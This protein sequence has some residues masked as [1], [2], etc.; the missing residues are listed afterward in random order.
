MIR[1]DLWISL[2][3]KSVHIN[4]PQV[5]L[6][7]FQKSCSFENSGMSKSRSSIC[8]KKTTLIQTMAVVVFRTQGT[9]RF[10]L[11]AAQDTSLISG[12]TAGSKPHLP[13]KHQHNFPNCGS[14]FRNNSQAD[15]KH[16]S[17]PGELEWHPTLSQW[18]W[19]GILRLEKSP[20]WDYLGRVDAHSIQDP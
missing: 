2:Q 10:F 19:Q 4:C 5:L 15:K 18:I 11:A 9:V 8:F 7:P 12:I 17:Q 13:L 3:S 20:T 1:I 16:L 14:G 6:H